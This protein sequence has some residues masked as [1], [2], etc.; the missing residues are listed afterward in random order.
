[1]HQV[2]TALS[3]S[4][5]AAGLAPSLLSLM[6]HLCLF[7]VSEE[8]GVRAYVLAERLVQQVALQKSNIAL[9]EVGGMK[10]QPFH[11]AVAR[12]RSY[13]QRVVLCVCVCVC[14]CVV[15]TLC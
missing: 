7:P 9:D 14:V 12:Q 10:W 3:K 6:R 4:A 15:L 8:G 1:M 11:F 13:L 5:K 2:F